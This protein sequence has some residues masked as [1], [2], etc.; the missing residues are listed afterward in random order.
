MKLYD[1]H[2]GL[3]ADGQHQGWNAQ[4]FGKAIGSDPHQGPGA[5]GVLASRMRRY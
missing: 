5:Y 4:G 1:G 2:D 3:L